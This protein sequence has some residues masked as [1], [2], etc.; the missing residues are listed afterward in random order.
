MCGYG[1]EVAGSGGDR[2]IE[3]GPEGRVG[4]WR[5]AVEKNGGRWDVV[6][7]EVGVEILV[8]D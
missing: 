8:A 6:G 4:S 7:R 3:A 5:E 1:V 2:G